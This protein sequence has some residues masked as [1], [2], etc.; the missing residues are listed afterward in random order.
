MTFTYLPSVA[1][2]EQA[3]WLPTGTDDELFEAWE[4]LAV[5]DEL[6]VGFVPEQKEFN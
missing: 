6:S 2:P 3:V 4:G 5:D 1:L